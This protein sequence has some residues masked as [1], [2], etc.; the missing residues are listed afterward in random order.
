[1][2]YCLI[3]THF[4]LVLRT[5]EPNLG[6]GMRWLKSTHAQDVNYRH[7]RT[8]HV[9]GGRYYSAQIH[10]DDHLLAALVYVYLNPVRA[11]IVDLPHAWPWSSFAATVGR[12]RAPEFLHVDSVLELFGPEPTVARARLLDVVRETRELDRMRRRGQTLRV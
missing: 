4:H 12:S 5:P 10:S 6:E 8:G 11:G 1:M 9:F 3:D 2:A 7:G